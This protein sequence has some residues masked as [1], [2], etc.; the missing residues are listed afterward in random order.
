[1]IDISNMPKWEDSHAEWRQ[2]SDGPIEAGTTF[3]SSIRVLAWEVNTD[4]RITAFEPGRRFA[5]EAMNG[6]AKGTKFSYVMKPMDGDRTSL[7]RVS[8][9]QFHG[10]AKLLRPLEAL[11]ARRN[12]GT[13]A[14]NVKRLLESQH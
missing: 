13:E 2:T 10:L 6:F 9:Y 3:Q 1:M 7:N 11:L 4:L 12:G 5:A 14:A 8:E